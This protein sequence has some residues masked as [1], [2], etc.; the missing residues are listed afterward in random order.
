[1]LKLDF[2]NISKNVIIS[3]DQVMEYTTH[4]YGNKIIIVFY[5]TYLI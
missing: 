4:K 1:M 2:S 5:V 3:H